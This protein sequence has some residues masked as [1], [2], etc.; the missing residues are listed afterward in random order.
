MKRVSLGQFAETFQKRGVTGPLLLTLE[1]TELT[2]LGIAST[3]DKHKLR[4]ELQLLL[5]DLFDLLMLEELVLVVLPGQ[6]L[7]LLSRS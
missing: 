6:L 1:D 4:F 3:Y 2:E 5:L 7:F